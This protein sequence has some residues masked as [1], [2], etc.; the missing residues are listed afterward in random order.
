MLTML[1]VSYAVFKQISLSSSTQPGVSACHQPPR[2]N[3][4]I[5][6]KLI[7]TREAAIIFT[8]C[9]FS[10]TVFAVD[11]FFCSISERP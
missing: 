10:E 7:H 11:L 4:M 1:K 8:I 2:I 9:T 3:L 5:P 6:K